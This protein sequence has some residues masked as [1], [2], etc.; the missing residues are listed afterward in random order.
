MV[1]VDM[2]AS[3][4]K[5]KSKT[6][7]LI[8]TGFWEEVAVLLLF[9]TSA[10]FYKVVAVQCRNEDTVPTSDPTSYDLGTPSAAIAAAWSAC[11]AAS[12]MIAS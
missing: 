9:G 12:P 10:R 1:A 11:T 5:A 3:Q 4:G 2:A 6:D 8:G 7:Y